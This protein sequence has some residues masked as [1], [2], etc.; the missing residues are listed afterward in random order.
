MAFGM[1]IRL[2]QTALHTA[3]CIVL[4][5]VIVSALKLAWVFFMTEFPMDSGR[6]FFSALTAL[7]IGV[8]IHAILTLAYFGAPIYIG[9]CFYSY[10]GTARPTV[11]RLTR[12]IP[13]SFA[14]GL[15]AV[16]IGKAAYGVSWGR[17]SGWGTGD[18][19]PSSLVLSIGLSTAA[20]A[21]LR[22]RVVYRDGAPSPE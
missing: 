5:A 13:A 10:F 4:A 2:I 22:H 16:L 12:W 18:E 8:G 15:L 9:C 17:F 20:F 19:L 6:A 14:M 7:P 21:I 1:S 11:W 3:W